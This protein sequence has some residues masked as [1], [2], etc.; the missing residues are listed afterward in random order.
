MTEAAPHL[1]PKTLTR[2]EKGL[3]ILAL[4][5]LGDPEAAAEVVQ[6]TL[7]RTL[8][9]LR[10]GQL[11]DSPK[12]TAFVHG[13]A[14]HVI[15]DVYRAR[16]RTTYLDPDTQPH[17]SG[18]AGPLDTLVSAEE[19]QR[20]RFA[21][22][23]LSGSDREVLRLSFDK[24][25]SSAEIARRLGEPAA[26]IRKRKSRALDRLRRAFFS[27]GHTRAPAST[28]EARKAEL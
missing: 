11:R 13:I 1:D 9:A 2:L 17:P 22:N 6:E 27:E 7:A 4:Q 16:K 20:L 8:A 5:S 12:L 15:A 25:L 14:R 18:A 23:G 26:R 21:L 28:R 3:R 19:R 10:A 24:A